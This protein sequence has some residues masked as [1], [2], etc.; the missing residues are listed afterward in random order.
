MHPNPILW[1]D[2]P[3]LDI[4]RV[5]DTWYMVSTTMH[6][7]PGCVIL[8][9]FDLIHW[10]TL[11]HVFETLDGTPA[12]R[13]EGMSHIYGQGMWAATLRH[14]RNRFYI[15]FV[16]NDT[17]KTYLYQADEIT[18]PWDKSQIR[19]FYHDCSLLFEEDRPFLVYGNNEIRLLE[20]NP[21]LSGPLP[22]GLDQVIVRETEPFHLGYEGAHFYKIDGRYHLFLIHISKS[23]H[24]RR[25]Q[26]WFSSDRLE[27]PYAGGDVLD[28]DM[29]YHNAGVAQGGIVDTPDGR[30]FSMLFQD[31]GAVGRVP[32]LVP[33]RWEEGRPVLGEYGLVPRSVANPSTRPEH[34]YAPLYGSDT[35]S[36]TPDVKGHGKLK[37]FW[38]WNHQPDPALWSVLD[39]PGTLRIQTDKVSPTLHHAANVLTQRTFGPACGAEVTVDGHALQPGDMAGICLLIGTYGM[40]AL[41]R[42]QD[43]YALVVEAKASRAPSIFEN[44]VDGIPGDTLARIPL[45]NARK[46]AGVR[47]RADCDFRDN[48][49]E[50]RFSYQ[51]GSQWIPLGPAHRMQYKLDHFMGARFGL[52]VQSTE[53][54]G[55]SA[56]FSDFTY[57]GPQSP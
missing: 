53:M 19:G 23:G 13:L 25:T 4:I 52:F 55:G 11:T 32:V 48:R 39:P 31:H 9:S 44:L 2:Y 36:G 43:G 7:M 26:A 1:A 38:Q 20:M 47:L 15:V 22:G 56:Q 24:Q 12:Q 14:H 41:R 35:F 17:H 33:M 50:V 16:A 54:P 40:I 5:Q 8:R 34:L 18:G 28:D 42:E 49:D 51:D 57:I 37:D 6:M 30:W 46:E 10:E 45:A 29:G 27:G 3:D 21:D